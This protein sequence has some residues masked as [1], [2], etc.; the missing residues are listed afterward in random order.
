MSS[1]RV[2]IECKAVIIK[3]SFLILDYMQIKVN[4]ALPVAVGLGQFQTSN[5]GS[6]PN[7]TSSSSCLSKWSHYLTPE[8][9]AQNQ[10]IVIKILFIR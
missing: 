2:A 7:S 6:C 3:L 1:S 10:G 4:L 8:S 9:K 5:G